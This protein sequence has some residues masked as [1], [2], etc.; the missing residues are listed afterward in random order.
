MGRLGLAALVAVVLGMAMAT[1]ADAATGTRAYE[2]VRQTPRTFVF[3]PSIR[4]DESLVDAWVR[5]APTGARP[6][7]VQRPVALRRIRLAARR[8]NGL[9]VRKRA[10]AREGRL[11]IAIS[12]NDQLGDGSCA[13]DAA[14]ITAV[15]CS[16]L[17]DDT[18]GVADPEDGLWG[19]IECASDSRHAYEGAGGDQ[20]PTA[21]GLPQRN[22]AYRRLTVLDG[23]DFWGERCELGRNTARYGENSA[24]QDSGTF[25]LYGAG[26][27]RITFFSQRYPA[28]FPMDVQAW[29]TVAQMKQAQ[30]AD[31]PGRG[32]VLELQLF[33]DQLRL[34]NSWQQ[35]WSTDA[36]RR[37]TW[38]RYALD[39]VYSP[40]P[41]VGSVQ[42]YVDLN[43]DGDA[44][45]A[46]ERSPRLSLQTELVET[47]GPNG[48]SDGLAPGDAIPDHLR[49]GIY[50]N[51]SISCPPPGGCSVDVDNVQVVG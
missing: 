42:V 31:N 9:V 6:T 47:D 12:R 29:Q 37:D 41:A 43:G 22:D 5:I 30:P 4:R 51:P 24:A 8:D 45:D 38:I 13:V 1:T 34:Q 26:E 48:L 50:H 23:D 20:S 40:D 19:S 36:P 35:A 16:V 3:R 28:S 32:P 49:L 11:V 15:D 14:T 21:A 10:D 33:G 7:V 17:R 27:H 39:V 44:L 2:P 25:A 46:G 18:A